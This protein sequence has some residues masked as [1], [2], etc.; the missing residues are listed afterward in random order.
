MR[1][2]VV[3]QAQQGDRRA[4]EALAADAIDRLYGAAVL[5]LHDRTLAEDAVQEALIRAW[6]DLP[7]LRDPDRFGPWLNRVLV[8]ACLDLVRHER[9]SRASHTIPE[10][11]LLGDDPPETDLLD[12]DEVGRGLAR[13]SPRE[14]SVLVLRYFL[15]LSVPEIADALRV[16]VGTAKSR[17]H[18]AQEAIRAAIEAD[19]RY[20][21]QGGLA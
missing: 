2:E 17:L 7:R 4:F 6:R 20:A 12:R 10:A 8:H 15:E 11:L 9:A 21:M 5:I 3:R 18:N 1:T 14:R 19:S 13:L 16:P